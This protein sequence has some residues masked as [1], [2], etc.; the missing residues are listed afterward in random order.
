[1]TQAEQTPKKVAVKK[2]PIDKKPV[3]NS[4]FNWGKFLVKTR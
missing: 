3:V 4:V 2:S 1:V